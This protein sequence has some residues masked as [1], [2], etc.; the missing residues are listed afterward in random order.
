VKPNFVW[1]EPGA[2]SGTGGYALF[3]GRLSEEKGL[4]TLAGAWRRLGG[5]PLLKA[6]G[7]G[8]MAATLEGV[9]GVER[10]GRQAHDGVLRLMR[11]ASF[12]V[13]PSLCYENLPMSIL[14]AFACGLPVIASRLGAMAEVVEDGR[15]GL[16][17]NPGDAGDLAAKVE[18]ATSHPA[19]LG[20]MRRE[21]R[22]EFEAHYTAERNYENLMEIYRKARA[23]RN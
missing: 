6:A 15:T 16:L 11:E 20:Q 2:G 9:P 19:A 1:P 13:F 21:A 5:K 23:A 10:L 8:P 12:L 7:D 17:F 22:A 3:A 18:W 14:E 4:G